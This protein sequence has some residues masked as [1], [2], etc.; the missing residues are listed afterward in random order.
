MSQAFAAPTCNNI[1][2]LFHSHLQFCWLGWLRLAADTSAMLTVDFGRTTTPMPVYM[3]VVSSWI[4]KW[5]LPGLTPCHA[6]V[7]VT[8]DKSNNRCLHS[9]TPVEPFKAPGLGLRSSAVWFLAA[10]KRMVAACSL[11]VANLT[12]LSIQ[13]LCAHLGKLLWYSD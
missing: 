8:R 5:R 3:V 9:T 4:A 2:P 6:I 13:F 10:V 11:L 1:L 7:I 12:K